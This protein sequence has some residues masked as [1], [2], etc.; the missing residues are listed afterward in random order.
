MNHLLLTTIAAVVLVCWLTVIHVVVLHLG[1]C[2]R[3]NN[4]E[5]DRSLIAAAREGNINGIK[6]HLANGAN[7]NSRD[8]VGA[9]SLLIA[10][11]ESHKEIAELLIKEGADVNLD[12]Y[13]NRTP[14]YRALKKGNLETANILRANG[15]V[16]ISLR[17]PNVFPVYKIT[18]GIGAVLVLLV[19]QL[20][21]LPMGIKLLQKCK[22]IEST[23]CRPLD[24]LSE[25]QVKTYGKA[26]SAID[27]SERPKKYCSPWSKKQCIYY[28]FEVIEEKKERKAPT[29]NDPNTF[30]FIPETVHRILVDDSKAQPLFLKNKNNCAGI[31]TEN[32]QYELNYDKAWEK[33]LIGNAQPPDC[34]KE[35]LN[36]CYG[37]ID[38]NRKLICKETT[39]ETGEDIYVFGEA[40]LFENK[41]LIKAGRL[42]LIVSDKGELGLT[43]AYRTKGNTAI[44]CALTFTIASTL[45]IYYVF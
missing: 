13:K 31:D 45:A 28:R 30:S 44:F 29:Y 22:L 42:P 11:G 17:K 8:A 32:I 3:Q 20:V 27:L 16:K 41:I 6:E 24:E 33:P 23:E 37:I 15:G 5:A 12:D 21:W 34:L 14:L 35:L 18:L 26:D 38:M 7:I 36:T 9:T 1:W 40:T 10:V 19:S 4:P 43:E 39:I 2:E 25:G